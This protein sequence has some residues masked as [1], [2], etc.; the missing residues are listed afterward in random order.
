[1]NANKCNESLGCTYSKSMDQPHPRICI[2]CGHPESSS[3]DHEKYSARNTREFSIGDI[4]QL[5][6][7]IEMRNRYVKG[8]LNLQDQRFADEDFIYGMIGECNKNIKEI[9]QLI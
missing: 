2:D 4:S 9:L 5:L 1:M 3:I 8:K 7:F 6:V